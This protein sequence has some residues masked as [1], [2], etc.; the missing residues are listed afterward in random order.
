[1]PG[2]G[3]FMKALMDLYP[4]FGSWMNRVAGADATMQRV[5]E[6]RRHAASGGRT[7]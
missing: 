1:M 6:L 2:P 7:V 4:G 3:R 5:I